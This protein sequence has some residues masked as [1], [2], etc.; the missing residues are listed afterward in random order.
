MPSE[1]GRN[2]KLTPKNSL[3]QTK[4]SRFKW[5]DGMKDSKNLQGAALNPWEVHICDIQIALPLNCD[6]KHSAKNKKKKIVKAVRSSSS[7]VNVEASSPKWWQKQLRSSSKVGKRSIKLQYLTCIPEGQLW[8][9]SISGHFFDNTFLLVAITLSWA[10][11]LKQLQLNSAAHVMIRNHMTHNHR[12]PAKPVNASTSEQLFKW[13]IYILQ[14]VCTNALLS[15][16]KSHRSAR[17][18]FKH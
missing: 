18:G 9:T 11:P 5:G 15:N 12:P 13:P 10:V 8:Y 17:R 3:H 6:K 7:L 2:P 1:A 16:D 4:V 14:Y